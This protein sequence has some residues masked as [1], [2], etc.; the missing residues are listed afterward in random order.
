M[1]ELTAEVVRRGSG[2]NGTDAGERA[3]TAG[4][5]V[6]VLERLT[7]RTGL[8]KALNLQPAGPSKVLG[9][10][11]RRPQRRPQGTEAEVRG[12]RRP[13]PRSGGGRTVP[14]TPTRSPQRVALNAQP[15]NSRRDRQARAVVR[16][17]YGKTTEIEEIRWASRFSDDSRL[18]ARYRVDRAFLA[19]DAAHTHFP[20]GG[21][22]LNLGVQDAMNLGW[23]LA[24]ELKGHAP[25]TLLDLS[26]LVSGLAIKYGAD[27]NTHP[28]T[29]TRL[30][31]F[32]AE[33]GHAS[34]WFH[35][36]K[37]VL[38]TTTPPRGNGG[39]SPRTPPAERDEGPDPPRRLRSK[40][41]GRNKTVADLRGRP[42]P[43]VQGAERPWRGSGGSTPRTECER[44]PGW[45]LSVHTSRQP[46]VAGTGFEPATSGL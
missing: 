35:K 20:A 1:R 11:R 5:D 22:G 41:N 25:P 14:S 21:Q 6:V 12:I 15:G 24:A 33:E 43:G 7:V 39:P 38:L 23:K 18:S 16:K 26:G 32:K 19:G 4:V 9:G 28:A 17:T 45:T 2:P 34:D 3:G 27:K 29:G 8:S 44:R 13:R 46:P 37:F 31:D 30:P 40:H 36:G 10:L 42:R